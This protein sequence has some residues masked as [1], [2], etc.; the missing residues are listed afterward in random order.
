MA[1]MELGSFTPN[2]SGNQTLS[3]AGTEIPNYIDFWVG[4]RTGT[5]ETANMSSFGSVD[6]TNGN[7]T[8]QSNFT[9]GTGSQTKNGVGGATTSS[10]LQHWVRSGGTLT[11]VIDIKFVSAASGQFTVNIVQN[12]AS[13]TVYCRIYG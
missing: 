3:L 9:D 12:N 7:A 8:W 5:T 11:K 4:P 10:C 6:I 1:V 2:P 13:Y